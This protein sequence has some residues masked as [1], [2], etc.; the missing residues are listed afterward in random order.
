[1]KIEGIHYEAWYKAPDHWKVYWRGEELIV[2]T[3]GDPEFENLFWGI[4]RF[5]KYDGMTVLKLS[6]RGCDGPR[7]SIYSTNGDTL[8]F[9]AIF[10]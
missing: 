9:M 5:L 8:A 10:I 6:P 4:A 7:G 3:L 2:D 1:M